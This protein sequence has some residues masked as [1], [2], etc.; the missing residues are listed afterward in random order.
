M[1]H[2]EYIYA[3]RKGPC[4]P[5]IVIACITATKLR[6]QIDCEKLKAERPEI[7]AFVWLDNLDR[8]SIF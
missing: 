4:S 5:V 6:V 2:A 8:I 7:F 1:D 3:F